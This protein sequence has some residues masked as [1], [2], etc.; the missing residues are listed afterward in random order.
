MSSLIV[1]VCSVDAV[2]T[3]PNAD[4]ME[5]AIIKGWKT[6]IVK[7]QFKGGDKCVYFPPDCVLPGSLSDRLGVTRYLGS[8]PKDVEGNRPGG[9]RVRVARLR[10][11]QSYGLIMACENLAWP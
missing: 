6:C 5:I 11:F 9:G 4:R 3:H 1:Q 10:G 2:E 7:G 8:L